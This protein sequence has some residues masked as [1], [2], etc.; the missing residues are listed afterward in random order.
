VVLVD[1]TYKTNCYNLPLLQIVECTSTGKTFCITLE[2]IHHERQESYEWAYMRLRELFDPNALPNVFVS[3]REQASMNAVEKV[4]PDA[5]VLLCCFHIVKNVTGKCKPHCGK[6]KDFMTFMQGWTDVMEAE[7]EIAFN[8]KWKNLRQSTP[9]KFSK[10]LVY[11]AKTWVIHK[12]RFVCA[13]TNFIK[14]RGNT[15]TNR[16]EGAHSKL[17]K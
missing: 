1:C 14:H 11:I 2:L 5:R 6:K 3:D 12:E 10:C 16:V 13:W 7:T 15:T 17:K 4:F 9:G 8:E